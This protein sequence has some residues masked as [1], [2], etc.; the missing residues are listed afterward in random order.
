MKKP[1]TKKAPA[2]K[3]RAK[4]V[5]SKCAPDSKYTGYITKGVE[6]VK[7]ES[8]KY[9]CYDNGMPPH[10]EWE[11]PKKYMITG[12]SGA[13][14]EVSTIPQYYIGSRKRRIIFSATYHPFKDFIFPKDVT[15][16][17]DGGTSAKL[18]KNKRTSI[19]LYMSPVRRNS[20][21]V[22][23]CAMA[24]TG[25]EIVCLDYS[26]Q[27]VGQAKQRLA[28]ARTDF[29]Y[30]HRDLFWQ[31]TYDDI[32][33]QHKKVKPKDELAVRLNGTSDLN[34]FEE[35]VNWCVAN[36]KVRNFPN[37]ILFYDYTKYAERVTFNLKQE[38]SNPL[39]VRHKVIYSLSEMKKGGVDSY[40]NAKKIL[41][42][43]GNIAAVFL[44]NPNGSST[45][46]TGWVEIKGKYYA[47]LP[48]TMTY[49]LDGK[50]Y[51]VQVLDGDSSDDLMLD[52]EPGVP[53]VFGLRAKNRGMDDKTGFAIPL[54]AID[55]SPS[56]DPQIKEFLLE[57]RDNE[58]ALAIA[59]GIKK[60]GPD[61]EFTCP[62]N[63]PGKC[64]KV[65]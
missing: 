53:Y 6:K 63:Q 36:G 60:A 21:A 7:F 32:M 9:G 4:K 30:A 18:S 57:L 1:T 39:G 15:F 42:R 34:L 22:Q 50:T 27:K 2:K 46:K 64:V 48:E 26:G 41:T 10:P 35:F 47:P 17:S 3:T 14:K 5:R 65:W 44:V 56:D 28:I 62:D 37:N 51:K 23:A 55:G 45:R 59:C 38:M 29:Y 11:M 52:V 54:Y 8:A 19:V 43:G 40:L 20:F 16:M 25:C 49:E 12:N 24:S 13:K 33:K 61:L 58:E 31:R